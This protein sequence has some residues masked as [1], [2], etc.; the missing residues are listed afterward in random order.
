MQGGKKPRPCLVA[1]VVNPGHAGVF[2]KLERLERAGGV[3]AQRLA[4]LR[5]GVPGAQQNDVF[6][7][8]VADMMSA[9]S[10]I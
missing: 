10:S 6:H 1:A 2:E 8:K 5:V 9:S 3:P 7:W 4:E